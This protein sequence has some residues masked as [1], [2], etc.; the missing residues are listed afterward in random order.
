MVCSRWVSSGTIDSEIAVTH[1]RTQQFR[2]IVR[3]AEISR[4]RGGGDQ[5]PGGVK[6]DI[7]T[8]SKVVVVIIGDALS[9]NQLEHEAILFEEW[10]APCARNRNPI[11]PRMPR[12]IQHSLVR[13]DTTY[14]PK[15]RRRV[16]MPMAVLISIKSDEIRERGAAY[17]NAELGTE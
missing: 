4:A 11:C 6:A 17:R 14:V 16:D 8:K 9:K 12:Q 3:I 7:G 2:P 5:V 13:H 15:E 1:R 10:Q